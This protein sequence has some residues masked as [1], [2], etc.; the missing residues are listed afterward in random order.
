[1][2]DDS[3]TQRGIDRDAVEVGIQGDEKE[4]MTASF[5]GTEEP[6]KKEANPFT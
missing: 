3:R 6:E 2:A 5:S 1:M 4:D